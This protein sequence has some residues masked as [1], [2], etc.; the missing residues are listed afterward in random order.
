MP[1]TKQQQVITWLEELLAYAKGEK[2]WDTSC[3]WVDES[4]MF[5][6]FEQGLPFDSKGPGPGMPP[7]MPDKV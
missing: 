1:P 7:Y 5:M 6:P 4:N 3:I 2:T